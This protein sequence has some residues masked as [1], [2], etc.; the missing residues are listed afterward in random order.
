M[1]TQLLST[2][3]PDLKTAA[4]IIQSGGLVAIPTETVYGLG[5]NGLNPDAVKR[6][7]EAKGRPQDNPLI[8]HIHDAS[9]LRDFCRDSSTILHQK[10]SSSFALK[11]ALM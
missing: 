2:S 8:L 10:C 11:Q 9:Q 1:T 4:A 3:E 5:A 7:F 6:I